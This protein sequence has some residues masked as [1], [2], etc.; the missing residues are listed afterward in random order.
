MAPDSNKKDHNKHSAQYNAEH[1]TSGSPRDKYRDNDD[2][3][4]PIPP[5]QRNDVK[6]DSRTAARGDARDDVGNTARGTDAHP[7]GPEGNDKTKGRPQHDS[8]DDDLER[9][10]K[11]HHG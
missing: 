3:R 11:K 5:D 10:N 1:N 8:F 7:T 9:D 4:N 2:E 6:P